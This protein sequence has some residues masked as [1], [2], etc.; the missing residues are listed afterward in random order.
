MLFTLTTNCD[1]GM[2][3]T[4]QHTHFCLILCLIW[5]GGRVAFVCPNMRRD[6]LPWSIG[7]LT[8]LPANAKFRKMQQNT[9]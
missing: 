7:G 3:L 1:G 9:N 4:T 2:L 6:M 5:H 8:H